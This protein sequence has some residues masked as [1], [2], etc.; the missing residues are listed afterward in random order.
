MII[1][2]HECDTDMRTKSLNR[3]FSKCYLHTNAYLEAE[4]TH[5]IMDKHNIV[6]LNIHFDLYTSSSKLL[7]LKLEKLE[8]VLKIK[9]KN[10][11]HFH[12]YY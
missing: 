7:P 2:A 9:Q 11:H 4:L 6:L 10:I 8:K 12:K 1:P 3:H 5:K